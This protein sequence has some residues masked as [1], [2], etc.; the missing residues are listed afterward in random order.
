MTPH[1]GRAH[2]GPD[3]GERA[4]GAETSKRSN[5][6]QVDRNAARNT[7]Y[8]TFYARVMGREEPED[9]PAWSSRRR[10]LVLFSSSYTSFCFPTLIK[11]AWH[12]C[13]IY[14]SEIVRVNEGQWA[15]GQNVPQLF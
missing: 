7:G 1:H 5:T 6:R 10:W 8:G 14:V 2:G 9:D 3:R 13:L 15:W 11:S 12:V 4:R